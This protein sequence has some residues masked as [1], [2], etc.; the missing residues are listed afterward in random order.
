[1]L[2]KV[3]AHNWSYS[4]REI[5]LL[6]RIMFCHPTV[7]QLLFGAYY[8][9]NTC[10][11]ACC[12]VGRSILEPLITQISVLVHMQAMWIWESR[13]TH[14]K[15]WRIKIRLKELKSLPCYWR[16]LTRMNLTFEWMSKRS[17]KRNLFCPNGSTFAICAKNYFAHYLIY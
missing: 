6:E 14:F 8:Y 17:C 16:T 12:W 15:D 13:E 10:C 5:K 7:F 1:M 11:D 9:S 4:L 3:F 2:K